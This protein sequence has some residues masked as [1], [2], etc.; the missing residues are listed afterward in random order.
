[1]RNITWKDGSVPTNEEVN[2]FVRMMTSP[3][4]FFLGSR[5]MNGTMDN[6]KVYDLDYVPVT[7]DGV[8]LEVWIRSATQLTS[9]SRIREAMIKYEAL[10]IISPNLQDINTLRQS[11]YYQPPVEDLIGSS[12][13]ED[14]DQAVDVG[15]IDED[16]PVD[17]GSL[18][19]TL[20]GTL[21]ISYTGKATLVDLGEGSTPR[22]AVVV[23]GKTI[24]YVNIHDQDS[25]CTFLF[26]V[27]QNI[28]GVLINHDED[29]NEHRV[30]WEGGRIVKHNS[31]K[32]DSSKK[33][34]DLAFQSIMANA[35]HDQVRIELQQYVAIYRDGPRN[36]VGMN[37]GLVDRDL[38]LIKEL[39]NFIASVESETFSPS[40][41]D[42][43]EWSQIT[44]NCTPETLQQ[45]WMVRIEYLDERLFG[46]FPSQR[47]PS[48]YCFEVI[49]YYL[50][51]EGPGR[52]DAL[53]A[54]NEAFP[55]NMKN[56]WRN[57]LRT[58]GTDLA[59][60]RLYAS[61]PNNIFYS[62]RIELLR[63]RDLW[64]ESIVINWNIPEA[65]IEGCVRTGIAILRSS[66]VN[67][68]QPQHG[69][70]LAVIGATRI[71]S[72][73]M[74]VA[75]DY[76]S[77]W[78]ANIATNDRNGTPVQSRNSGI[79]RM[80]VDNSSKWVIWNENGL[81]Y[82]VRTVIDA[83][84]P[85]GIYCG[86]PRLL[87]AP[88]RFLLADDYT[89]EGKLTPEEWQ[90]RHD[91]NYET[92]VDDGT[93]PSFS[94]TDQNRRV[95]DSL[96]NGQEHERHVTDEEGNIRWQLADN[97]AGFIRLGRS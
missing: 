48:N 32:E 50:S 88:H 76:Y 77:T 33:K 85:E 29:S 60:F 79:A 30:V 91:E 31:N 20:I 26:G 10:S 70:Y 92:Y 34:W 37:S 25:L 24:G 81:S 71:A 66:T 43:P 84:P 19:I 63:E 65:P 78:K 56:W 87:P 5:S 1:M 72:V 11:T 38:Q 69:D 93:M 3:T 59:G 23:S 68:H 39:H 28:E 55:E 21:N 49:G 40:D 53:A 75:G 35:Q 13:D 82:Y 57:L 94:Y 42:Q 83:D 7:R 12:D 2:Q 22:L 46:L 16:Q 58:S 80:R 62:E 96:L 14:E 95:P 73:V 97:G 4:I 54:F 86:D 52:A 45:L 61:N 6:S 27:G 18:F 90:A 17:V 44:L 41:I 64:D 36:I 67:I 89:E 15:E 9:T 8:T 74:G 51:S 47:G